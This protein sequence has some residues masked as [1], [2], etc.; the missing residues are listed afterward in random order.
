VIRLSALI[1]LAAMVL[2]PSAASAQSPLGSAQRFAVLGASTVTNTGATLI[3]GDAGVSPGT[4]LTGFLPPPANVI[5]GPGT[6][7][8]GLGRVN[9]TIFAGGAVAAQAHGDANVAYARFGELAC[10]PINNLSGQVLGAGVASLGPGVYC[11]DSSSRSMSAL[12][13]A[14]T[15]DTNNISLCSSALEAFRRS[16]TSARGT[17]ATTTTATTMETTTTRIGTITI[18]TVG[19]IRTAR[20]TKTTMTTT[21]KTKITRAATTSGANG[22]AE[23]RDETRSDFG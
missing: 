12:T 4:A 21:T 18:R 23:R 10:P 20:T 14:V 2:S 9:G 15:L 19:T 17:T 8:P 3:T 7:T 13:G 1:V 22:Q 5:A 11:F 16:C 6:V